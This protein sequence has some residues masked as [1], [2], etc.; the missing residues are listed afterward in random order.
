MCRNLGGAIG[1]AVMQTA[2]TA[3]EHFHSVVLT[4][5]VSLLDPATRGTLTGL[6]QMFMSRGVSDPGLAWRKAAVAVGGFV[7]QQASIMAFS[8]VIILQS[9]LLGLALVSILFLKPAT[10]ASD[11]VG[12]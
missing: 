3:R 5:Q 2:L 10:V 7:R 8:D 11:A 1:I 9:V 12:H 4:S 6:T